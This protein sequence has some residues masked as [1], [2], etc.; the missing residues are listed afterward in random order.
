MNN[1]TKTLKDNKPQ[2][3]MHASA[4]LVFATFLVKI[5]GAAYKIPLGSEKILDVT[6]MGYFSTAYD[7]YVPMY[8]IAM[9]GLPIAISRIVAEHVAAGRYRHVKKTL[10]VAKKAFIVTG[11]TGF[12]LMLVLA[13]LMTGHPFNV[14]NSGSFLGIIA[15]A[16]CLL[17]CCVMSAY[18]GY[19][20]G[21][22]NMTPTAVSQVIE[23]LGKLVFGLL[24]S[25]A[26][27]ITTKNYSLA[28]AGALF[29]ITLGT[30]FSSGYLV[31]KYRREK[32]SFFTKEQLASSPEP[33]SGKVI[34]KSL[35]IVAIPIVLGSLVN[36]ITSLID[37]VM[38]QRQLAN[39]LESAPEYFRNTFSSLIAS[40]IKADPEYNWTTDLP[41][42]LY[43]C[44]R[45]FAFSIYNLVPVLTSVLGV[46]AIPVLA[47]AWTKRDRGEMKR[48]VG[49]IIRTTALI[50]IPVGCG[51]FAVSEGILDILYSNENMIAV[52]A[53]NLRVL[54]LCAIFAGLNSPIVNMLQA[55][56]KQSVP[57]RNIAV[58]AVLKIIINFILVGTPEINIL[59]AP[60]GTTVCYAYICIANFICFVKYSGVVPNLYTCIGKFLLSGIACGAAAFGTSYGLIKL[61]LS[62]SIS[63]VLAIGAAAFVYV[64]F[65][66]VLRALVKD[67]ILS[68]PKGEKIAK[69]LEKLRIM[70]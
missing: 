17:F 19:Y 25:I 34:L 28:A 5:I 38:V 18:R 70:R 21:L 42:S 49:S 8:S 53:P 24:F 26:I 67:D 30:V 60:I 65:L 40:E 59:G 51:I 29:G 13:V 23:A 9:A 66:S 36:N 52:A 6:G 54:G 55:I 41:N 12:I 56:G 64:V 2:S 69:V 46:S 58:G 1:K 68:L 3:Y 7:L 48:S 61:G 27:I 63:T 37:V 4:I 43:G 15:I 57:I 39:A 22:R 10:D 32:D 47:T 44:H 11:G 31:L 62:L 16:P 14:F 50:A 45:G 20:E 33:E 35:L